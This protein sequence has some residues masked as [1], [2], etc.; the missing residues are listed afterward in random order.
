M[1]SELSIGSTGFSTGP[2]ISTEIVNVKS[3]EEPS[4]QYLRTASDLK[5][6]E[7]KGENVTISDEQLIKAIDRAIKAMQ[8]SATSLE[9]SIHDQTKEI[10]IKVMNT[11]TGEI[12]REIPPEKT[13]DFVA[14]MWQMAG[15]LV[16]KKA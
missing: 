14:R 11:D 8:G 5:R 13:L 7:L 15:I 2:V 6:A 12:I 9:F 3:A 16:D 4:I 10:M 1:N